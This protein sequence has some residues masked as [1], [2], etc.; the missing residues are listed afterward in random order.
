M[1]RSPA[2]PTKAFGMV[3]GEQFPTFLWLLP[4]PPWVWL[5][6]HL[7]APGQQGGGVSSTT[8]ILSSPLHP[9]VL[10]GCLGTHH[11]RGLGCCLARD[12]AQGEVEALQDPT[13]DSVGEKLCKEMGVL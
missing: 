6:H 9:W 8:R 4:L 12:T 13:D 11:S 3:V 1:A 10:G 5:S 7:L 2:L